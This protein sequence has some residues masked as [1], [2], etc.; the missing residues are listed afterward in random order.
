MNVEQSSQYD[1]GKKAVLKA[2]KLVPEVDWQN[3]RN[4][5]Q[6]EKQTYTEFA[7]EKEALFDRWCASKEVERDFEKLHQLASACGGIQKLFAK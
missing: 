6:T 2:Y 1:Y 3:F 5:K 7:R 4:C